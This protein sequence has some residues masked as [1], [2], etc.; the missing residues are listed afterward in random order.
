MTKRR[1]PPKSRPKGNVSSRKSGVDR[2]VAVEPKKSKSKTCITLLS[3]KG[4]AT[5]EELQ[6]A[7]GWQAHSVRG[8]LSGT[9]K[10]M[11]GLA[12]TSEKRSDLPRHYHVKSA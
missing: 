8:F 9:V 11:A 2:K 12:L 5:I 6:Q 10:K 7:T 1:S 4:G 3:R